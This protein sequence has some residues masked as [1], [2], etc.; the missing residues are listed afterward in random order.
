MKQLIITVIG[1]DKTGLVEQLSDT[2][3]NNGANWLKSSLTQAQWAICRYCASGS[4]SSTY[5]TA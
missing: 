5:S 1:K 3:Y 2:V 4:F